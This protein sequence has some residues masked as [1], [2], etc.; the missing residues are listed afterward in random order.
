MGLAKQLTINETDNIETDQNK[1]SQLIFDKGTNAIQWNN[2]LESMM[3][4]KWILA[5][6]K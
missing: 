5:C 3:L 4:N 2:I 6:K 1:Y